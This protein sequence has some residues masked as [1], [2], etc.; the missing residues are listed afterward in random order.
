[1]KVSFVEYIHRDFAS[2]LHVITCKAPYLRPVLILK[3]ILINK[4]GTLN[5]DR[6]SGVT[7]NLGAGIT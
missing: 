6:P 7:T 3:N 2:N 4:L 5:P 1:M